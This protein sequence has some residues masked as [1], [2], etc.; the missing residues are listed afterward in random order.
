MYVFINWIS[1]EVMGIAKFN[2]EQFIQSMEPGLSAF[3]I[4]QFVD[5]LEEK[6][7]SA[8]EDTWEE[9]RAELPDKISG[10]IYHSF[11]TLCG[12][13]LIKIEVDFTEAPKSQP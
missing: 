3:I 7:N 5:R 1:E 12:E 11:N 13:D 4:Q 8:V 2:K 6:L 9:M 10:K